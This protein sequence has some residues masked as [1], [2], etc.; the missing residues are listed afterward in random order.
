LIIGA[1]ANL[2]SNGGFEGGIGT[3]AFSWRRAAYRP[4]QDLPVSTWVQRTTLAK[5]SGSYGMSI[6]S[7]NPLAS[8]AFVYRTIEARPYRNYTLSAWTRRVRGEGQALELWFYDEN[9]DRLGYKVLSNSQSTS[10]HEVKGS[11]K[12]PA[13]AA[14]LV[15][16]FGDGGGFVNDYDSTHYWDDL[17][18]VATAGP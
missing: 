16:V 7:P 11:M 13:R 18:L 1:S 15:V 8:Y 14:K 12:A 4:T 5:R 2:L 17:R 6:Q 9:G 10:W 3:A